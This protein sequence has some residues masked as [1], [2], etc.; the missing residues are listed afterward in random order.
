MLDAPG[1]QLSVSLSPVWQ[2]TA[3]RAALRE[4][5][6]RHELSSLP[7]GTGDL[8]RWRCSRSSQAPR[9]RQRAKTLLA[10][11]PAGMVELTN[12]II[13]FFLS[14]RHNVVV[15]G[16]TETGGKVTNPYSRNSDNGNGLQLSKNRPHRPGVGRVPHHSPLPAQT[17]SQLLTHMLKLWMIK[18]GA[19]NKPTFLPS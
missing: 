9:E 12:K 8:S 13:P 11:K 18:T 1:S 2:S 3:A 10:A 17:A 16:V 19:G 15:Q 5:Q 7:H 14:L 6:T 4:R